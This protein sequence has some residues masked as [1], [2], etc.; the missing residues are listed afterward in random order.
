MIN[1]EAYKKADMS[2]FENLGS[3]PPALLV[4]YGALYDKYRP[5]IEAEKKREN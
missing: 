5:A 2:I 4:N 3:M 1:L